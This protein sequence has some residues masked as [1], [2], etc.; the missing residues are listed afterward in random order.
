[1][2]KNTIIL[3][4]IVSVI[5]FGLLVYRGLRHSRGIPVSIDTIEKPILEVPF[6][7]ADI[8]L[9][10]GISLNKWNS[11]ASEE[12]E[13]MYQ[14]TILPWGKSLV[15]PIT[16]KA[17]HNKKNIYFYIT[18]KDVTENRVLKRNKFS[19]GCAIMF[20][21]DEKVQPSTLMMGFMGKANIWHW[22]ASRDETY[23]LKTRPKTEAYADFHYPFEEEELFTVSQEKV[24]SAVNDLMAVRVA[25]I[26]PKE[27]QDVKGRG[28]WEDG[29]W[30]VVFKRSLKVVDPEIDAVFK[31]N[32]QRLCA[33][34]VWNGE[35]GDRGGRKSISDWVVLEI[36]Q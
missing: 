5:A 36:K 28:F 6:M 4:C 16:V 31:F 12:I 2:K 17:F 1:M 19:D 14:V 35:Q 3:I 8:D 22:K 27:R 10:K 15:S 29:I 20:P 13:L 33:F 23:W 18:W 26:T 30:H 34:A 9:N 32:E 11:L 25:T 7:D 21:M 24:Q